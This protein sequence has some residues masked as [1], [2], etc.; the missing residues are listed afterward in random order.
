MKKKLITTLIIISF[1]ILITLILTM[2]YSYAR[3]GGGSSGSSSGG[4]GGNPSSSGTSNGNYINNP[5]VMIFILFFFI[6][7]PHI[8]QRFY[9][10]FNLYK[11][12]RLVK[13]KLI[14][15]SFKNNI[16]DEKKIKKRI[17]DT[18]KKVQNAWSN[19]D[20]NTLKIYLTPSLFEEWK[21][22]IEWQQFNNKRNVLK[23]IKLKNYKI[24]SINDNYIWVYIEGFMFDNMI[25]QSSNK[26]SD[27]PSFNFFYEYWQFEL[28]DNNFYLS[29]IKQK[30]EI[31]IIDFKEDNNG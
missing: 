2:T 31:N 14:N 16:Y 24:I 8:V 26:Y 11:L 3:A 21:L 9:L 1:T 6:F 12:H 10:K 22:K 13:F 30:D 20:L 19:Q 15:Y 17:K 18:Y 4:G 5:I 28:I 23:F 25:N 7:S 29:M 27:I